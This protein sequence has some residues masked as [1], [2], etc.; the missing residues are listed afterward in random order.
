ME[1]IGKTYL[2]E[3]RLNLVKTNKG[4]KM[5][6]ALVLLMI[7]SQSVFGQVMNGANCPTMEM[8]QANYNQKMASGIVVVNTASQQLQCYYQQL[9]TYWQQLDKTNQQLAK[10][11][12]QV[13]KDKQQVSKDLQQI[14]TD[15]ILAEKMKALNECGCDYDE[16]VKFIEVIVPLLPECSIK[17]EIKKV[18][19]NRSGHAD[20]TSPGGQTQNLN[21]FLN[22]GFLNKLNKGL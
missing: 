4:N 3:K 16:V 8:Q 13:E 5:K 7:V 2:I 6:Y 19:T 14:Q 9:A 12:Q 20:G 17:E 21:G 18:H 11:R 10:D 22:P 1:C 15:R